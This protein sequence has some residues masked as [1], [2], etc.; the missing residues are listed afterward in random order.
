MESKLVERPVVNRSEE[1]SGTP[2]GW[3]E[4][5]SEE[6]RSCVDK[7]T[8]YVQLL[9]S[10]GSLHVRYHLADLSTAHLDPNQLPAFRLCSR[11]LVPWSVRDTIGG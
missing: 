8:Q 4:L 9:R 5:S 2:V 1:V 3:S 7:A 6:S 10:D 11:A